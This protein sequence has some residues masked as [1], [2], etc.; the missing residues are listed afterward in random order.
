[1]PK[2]NRLKRYLVFAWEEYE[3][4]GGFNDYIDSY[5]IVEEAYIKL[6]EI[7]ED[8]SEGNVID[9]HTGE[10]VLRIYWYEKGGKI[11]K[12][13]LSPEAERLIRETKEFANIQP[14]NLFGTSDKE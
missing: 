2:N 9:S 1:M 11:I 14:I 4:G 12:K 3:A 7:S 6:L 8:L 10:E 5:N 13:V